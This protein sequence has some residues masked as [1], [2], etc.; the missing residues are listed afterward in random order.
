MCCWAV[1][2]EGGED[3]HGFGCW[4]TLVV[5]VRGEESVDCGECRV[6]MDEEWLQFV[7]YLV[8]GE[9]GCGWR[10]LVW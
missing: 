6:L 9:A 10:L 1:L 5:E 4:G 7:E 8:G 2:E 3:L